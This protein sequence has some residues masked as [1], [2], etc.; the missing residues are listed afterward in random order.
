MPI[1]P[2]PPIPP[3]P[4]R[5]PSDMA[6]RLALGLTRLLRFFADTFFAKRYGHRGIVL[7]TIA[8]VPGMVGAMATHLRC[9]RCMVDDDGWIR[10]RR[11]EAENERMRPLRIWRSPC[12]GSRFDA[13][14]NV[15]QGPANSD[16]AEIVAVSSR[17]A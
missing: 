7:E 3:L 13:A 2:L 17:P 11:E 5:A 15:I 12:H 9:L 4:H 6:D 14:G 8:A 16:L 10:T 1:E